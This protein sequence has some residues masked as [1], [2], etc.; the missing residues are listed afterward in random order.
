M[1]TERMSI[2]EFMNR[3]ETPSVAWNVAKFGTFLPL[4]VFPITTIKASAA[5]YEATPVVA[6]TKDQIYDKMLTAFEPITNLIQ[7]LAYPVASIVVLFGAIMVLISQKEK[8]FTLMSNAG[9]GVILVNLMPML[10]NILVD[11]MK[12]F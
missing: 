3:K 4:A 12:G 9:L 2:K 5:T 6:M 11:I 1:K 7:A 8:G 10:L